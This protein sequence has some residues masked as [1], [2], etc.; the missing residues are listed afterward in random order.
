MNISPYILMLAVFLIIAIP[1]FLTART[2]K[3][4]INYLKSTF[5]KK[6]NSFGYE[7]KSIKSYHEYIDKFTDTSKQIDEITWNDLDMD[8]VFRRVNACHTSVGEEYLYQALHELN[9]NTKILE[10]RERLIAF[11]EENTDIR[12]KIQLILLQLGKADYNQLCSYIFDSKSKMIEH[13][14]VYNILALMPVVFAGVIFLNTP[15]GI[16]LLVLSVLT[17]A[18]IYFR[19]KFQLE[20]EI[21]AMRY[22]SSILFATSKILKIEAHDFNCQIRELGE[23]FSVFK[24]IKGIVSNSAQKG[25]IPFEFLAD[26]YK[27]IF[28]SDIRKY[29]RVI[30]K[31]M[32][33]TESFHNLYKQFGEIDLALCILSFRKSLKDYC[34]PEYVEEHS[35][36]F[37]E[38]YHPLLEAPITNSGD[39]T[40]NS[41]VSGPNASGKSTFIKALALNS[42]FA[43]SINTCTAKQFI[44]R[45][46][47]VMTSMAVRDDI[48]EGDSYFITEIKSLKRVLDKISEVPCTCFIDEIL[49]GTNT[50]ERIAASSAILEY[51][52]DK[53]CLCIVASHDI[54]LTKI[55]EQICENYHFSEK[56]GSEGVSFNFKL[57]T[58]A[59]NTK[60][61][62]RLLDYMEY[63]KKIVEDANKRV[64]GFIETGLWEKTKPAGNC[65]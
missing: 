21:S 8:D 25:M 9:F 46:S 17:N 12:T 4:L 24:G 58:G 32:N 54:E 48:L 40:R 42:I 57:K 59:A 28:L 60:N 11:F 18:I 27:M 45:H 14:W 51:L 23:S 37:T 1:F 50:I 44:I 34:I 64:S 41:I 33:E 19:K 62:I 6:P 39:I 22:F 10:K 47:L 49:R 36:K 15:W 52:S 2:N 7:L 53:N 55:M 26:Y 65:E 56:V 38:L 31:I 30:G 61:A 13:S 29:N 43:Q 20:S 63:D 16:F 3:R 35:V 5:G